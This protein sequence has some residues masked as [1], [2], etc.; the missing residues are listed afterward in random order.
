[1]TNGKY[2]VVYKKNKKKKH[3]KNIIAQSMGAIISTIIVITPSFAQSSTDSVK[4]SAKVIPFCEMTAENLSFGD[5]TPNGLSD[6]GMSST[7]NGI[8]NIVLKCTKQT[9]YTIALGVGANSPNVNARRL[10]SGSNQYIDY[11]IC[12]T[13]SF[14]VDRCAVTWKTWGGGSLVYSGTGNGLVQNVPMYGFVKKDYY[15]AG[16]YSDVMV[17]TIT[18]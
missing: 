14:L 15:T 18:Y 9:S 7:A 5:I 1:M 4:M 12:Q 17:A 2:N 3:M 10:K 11:T 13:N 6:V 16:T 8:S